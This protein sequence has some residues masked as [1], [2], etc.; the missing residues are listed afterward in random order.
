MYSKVLKSEEIYKGF[1]S[2]RKDTIEHET[3]AGECVTIVREIIGGGDSVSGIILNIQKQEIYLV[4]QY[5]ATVNDWTT[6]AVAG[7]VDDGETAY[8]AFVREAHEELGVKLQFTY[9]LPTY[10]HGSIGTKTGRSY[11]FFAIT[12]ET[13]HDFA[14]ENSH[15]DIR[16]KTYSLDAFD[17]LVHSGAF[18]DPK[19]LLPYLFIKTYSPKLLEV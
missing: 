13:P 1:V 18:I 11:H 6:E 12:V 7:M 17:R 15:E 14:G 9:S 2:L 19:I 10:T 5:R 8:E 3:Y 4:E 16:I